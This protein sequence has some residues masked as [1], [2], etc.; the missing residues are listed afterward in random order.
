MLITRYRW[1]TP[2]ILAAQEHHGLKSVQ[3]NTLLEKTNAKKGWWG[4]SRSRP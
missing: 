1:F 4:G 3:T 2:V